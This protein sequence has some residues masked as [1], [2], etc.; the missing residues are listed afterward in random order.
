[1]SFRLKTIASIAAAQ[2][3]V[4]VILAVMNVV[5]FSSTIRAEFS[6]R[7]QDTARLFAATIA[8]AVATADLPALRTASSRLLENADFHLI[9]IRDKDWR[10]IVAA[11]EDMGDQIDL[12]HDGYP[13][14]L[15]GDD[16][17]SI[18]TPIRLGEKQIG[19]VQL[20]IATQHVNTAIQRAVLWNMAVSFVAIVLILN[21]AGFLGS[22]LTRRLTILKQGAA[23]IAAGEVNYELPVTGND[24][25]AQT[26]AFLNE[27]SR[28]LTQER[29]RLAAREHEAGQLAQIAE[30]ANEAIMITDRLGRIGWANGAFTTLTGYT[31]DEAVGRKLEALLLLQRT[32]TEIGQRL[33]SALAHGRSFQGEI[34]CRNKNDISFWLDLNIAPIREAHGPTEHLIV[35][36][37]DI[38]GR[39]EAEAELDKIHEAFRHHALHDPLTGLGNRQ[40]ID[41]ALE[42]YAEK[43][44]RSLAL[45]HID[46]DGFK[47]IN[48]TLGHAAGDHVLLHVSETLK[49]KVGPDDSL[50]RVGG[51]EFLLATRSGDRVALTRLANDL[52]QVL[53]EPVLYEQHLCRL[54]ASI[55]IAVAAGDRIDP[56]ALMVGADMALY[57]AKENGRNRYEFFSERLQ[58]QVVDRKRLADDI[59][60]GIESREFIPFYQPQLDTH[61]LE[62]VGA[63]ALV[64]WQHPEK[65]M[66]S[67]FVFLGV[68]EDL[69][70]L[71]EIDKMLMEHALADMRRWKTGGVNIPKISVNISSRRLGDPDLVPSLA[72][73]DLTP[74]AISFEILE[75]IFLDED[76]E[77]ISANIEG[78]KSL[79]IGLEID[80]FGTGHASI[81]S[82]L[83][84]KPDRLK[85]DRQLI[86]PITRSERQKQLVRAIIEIGR[87]Q[88]ILVTAEGVET[89]EQLMLLRQLGC[90]TAQGFYFSRPLPAQDFEKFAFGESR[91]ESSAKRIAA[92]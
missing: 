87:S 53:R 10:E 16:H 4:I 77:Q 82:L 13:E 50:A 69:N 85:I 27:M 37:R 3:V 73:L 64:R 29:A 5:N 60:R 44:T 81:T 38:T 66:L 86:S 8:D 65:G 52:L 18:T 41:A 19:T 33:V 49:S 78:I 88:D 48:D 62:I 43:F 63:E 7:A 30:Q 26:A 32:G 55:G 6:A 59:L 34:H 83:K 21:Y 11:G 72:E 92:G 31:F 75:S 39:K 56:K 61:S 40:Y 25:L 90:A 68:A 74:G 42:R 24:E 76:N 15:E 2:L 23:R 58:Q 54:S 36:A 79:G 20:A 80:D 1:V 91:G 17:V 22:L 51:D 89:A 45:L 67:P 70:V 12:L 46:L 47:Q 9:R 57:R 14:P 35:L 84:L 71:A 28:K